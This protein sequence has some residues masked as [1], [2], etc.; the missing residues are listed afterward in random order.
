MTYILAGFVVEND[1]STLEALGKL[2]FE[3]HQLIHSRKILGFDETI[4]GLLHP[5][6][7]QL[8]LLQYV[9]NI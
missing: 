6:Q 1:S 5:P 2:V 4:E 8:L 9:S 3:G 7:T